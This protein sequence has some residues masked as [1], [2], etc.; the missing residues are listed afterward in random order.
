MTEY[1]QYHQTDQRGAL[2]VDE[3][4]FRAF[5]SN[6]T[7]PVLGRVVWLISG[8]REAKGLVYRLHYW[9]VA[10]QVEEGTPTRLHGRKGV[11]LEVPVVLN[12]EPWF[13]EFQRAQRN[14]S[15]GLRKV[16]PAHVVEL[17]RVFCRALDA[18]S[19]RATA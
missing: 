5:T 19:A 11:A 6:P 1:V 17:E 4:G 15:L 3:R 14:F 18:E 7:A 2:V 13:R 12:D 16:L 8:T 10:N 9:F